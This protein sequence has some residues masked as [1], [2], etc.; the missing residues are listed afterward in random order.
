MAGTFLI[1]AGVDGSDGGH[2][3]LRWAAHEAAARGGTVQAVTAWR[4]DLDD[5][6]LPDAA[7]TDDPPAAAADLL[8][9]EV[10]TLPAGVPVA[11]QVREGRPADVLGDAARDADL[12]VVGSHGHSRVW[13]TV[14]GSVAEECIR[15][16]TCPVV[17]IPAAPQPPARPSHEVS[18]RGDGDG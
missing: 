16:A 2:R 5:A 8:A 10:A 12:L 9:Q 7:G 4:W 3:A 13:Y 14:L 18:L 17:V 1:V 6:G 15:K 11:T